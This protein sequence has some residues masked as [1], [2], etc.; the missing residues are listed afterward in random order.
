MIF[1]RKKK[2]AL[3]IFL[4]LWGI[5]AFPN[6]VSAVTYTSD[7]SK[8]YS[9][10]HSIGSFTS[11]VAYGNGQSDCVKKLDDDYAYCMEFKKAITNTNYSK[12]SSWKSNSKQAIVCG[13]IIE[14]ANKKY[15]GVQAYAM[16]AI[17]LNT[18]SS[19]F[20]NNPNSRGNGTESLNG[21]WYQ[22]NATIKEFIDTAIKMYNEM[23]LGTK[24]PS[25]QFEA[26]NKVMN[27]VSG[28]TFISDKIKVKGL[29]NSFGGDTVK[30]VIKSS[31]TGGKVWICTDAAGK[32][33]Q[34]GSFEF[35][36]EGAQYEFYVKASN[37]SSTDT[38]TVNIKGSNSS[39]Y[40]TSA[41]YVSSNSQRLLVKDDFDVKRSVSNSMQLAIPSLTQHKIVG[42]KVDESGELLS[43]ASLEI[44]K[45]DPKVAG[46]LL[47][48][49]NGNASTVSYS[50]P[51]VSS[52]TDDFFKHNYYLVEKVAPNG[53]VLSSS[54]NQFYISGTN[55]LGNSSCLYNGGEN[56]DESTIVQDTEH[57]NFSDYDYMCKS[58]TGEIKGLTEE[59]NCNFPSDSVPSPDPD[60]STEGSGAEGG[61]T[62]G[63]T[64]PT[65]PDPVTYEKICYK[66]STS[67]VA[68]DTYCDDKGKYVSV[69]VN[70]NTLVVTQ[71]NTK[72][73][74]K[75]SKKAITGDDE[76]AGAELKICT[77]ADY[78]SKKNS[79]SAAKTIDDVEMAWTS[80]NNAQE[81][82]GLSKG[83]YYIIE[84][85]PP[86]GY[87]LATTV[88]KFSIDESGDVKVGSKV[89][90]N[91]DFNK[92]NTSIVIKNQLSSITV[93]KQDIATSAELPGA[94]ISICTTYKDDD[95]KIQTQ[96]DKDSNEC[97]PAI[98][99]DGSTA[100][101]VSEDQPKV[102]TGLPVGTYYLVEKIAPTDYATAES[103]LFT[104][105]SDGSLV[106]EDGKS[107]KDHKLI[108]HDKKI[109]EV[110][111]GMLSVY[112]VGG[113][114]ILA[115]ALGAGSYYY[116]NQKNGKNII[117]VDK[118][119]KRKLH[120]TGL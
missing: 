85:V 104:L 89:I 21:L 26:S 81:Y 58:S 49:N 25:V 101:W 48:K 69:W 22:N 91:D 41:R 71:P 5:V 9:Y 112:L 32:N 57:C 47:T 6:H 24:L 62:E 77:E 79:C 93:S 74:V 120:K 35:S 37:I 15:S 68:L 42:Y 30:Y 4:V 78:N 34:E 106:D 88:T 61:T 87:I 53:Y 105:K 107:L 11:I 82:S 90:T 7:H 55:S 8:C 20:L 103:I 64:T 56:T 75:I 50:A 113:F 29:V 27:Y 28:T 116:L 114:I 96:K 18:Y 43:G 45:D 97:I 39:T 59:N 84:E 70:G 40:F 52:T 95:G 19:K 3:F 110:K 80:G 44:Y 94:T 66:K 108:M 33:C 14:L 60:T 65:V 92:N 100:T 76:I 118:I 12:D 23:E 38:V 73:T 54:V 115:G 1:V 10:N 99:A 72:N 36:R 86:A 98:L 117:K 2:N 63:G 119:R 31:T 102:I 17:T 67:T 109:D 51:I 16:T 46:N 111:T 83:T 13:N